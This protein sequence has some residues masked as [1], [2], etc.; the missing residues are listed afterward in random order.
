MGSTV[1]DMFNVLICEVTT[2]NSKRQGLE[3]NY[4]SLGRGNVRELRFVLGKIILDTLGCGV[5]QEE[6]HDKEEKDDLHAPGSH[7]KREIFVEKFPTVLNTRERDPLGKQEKKRS[8]LPADSEQVQVVSKKQKLMVNE[9]IQSVKGRS[10]NQVVAS[11]E[12][13][14]EV[15]MEQQGLPKDYNCSNKGKKRQGML[16]ED[17]GR[18]F[19]NYTIKMQEKD[20]SR[21]LEIKSVLETVKYQLVPEPL[22][23][24]QKPVSKKIAKK[25][26]KILERVNGEASDEKRLPQQDSSEQPEPVIKVGRSSQSQDKHA[27]IKVKESQKTL[28]SLFR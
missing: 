14:K 3:I 5:A 16:A 11:N 2:L 18:K 25:H 13:L 6:V 22:A 27:K 17:I 10:K 1:K 20:R 24:D 8:T 9:E 12:W 21:Q 26:L 7:Q 15:K 23:E 28:S 4:E 19:Q